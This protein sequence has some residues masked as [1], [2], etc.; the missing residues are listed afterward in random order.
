MRRLALLPTLLACLTACLALPASAP[1]AT[2]PVDVGVGRADITPPTGYTMMG[3]VRSDAKIVGQHTRLWARVIVLRQ[4]GRKVALVAE[5]LNGIPGGMLAQAA[6]A[7]K[8]IGYSQQ[9][10]LDSASHTHAAPTSFYNFSTY[11]S[12]FM[13]VRSPT[14][15]DLQGTVDPQLYAF[16]VRRLALAIRRADQNL[17]PGAVGWGST[18]IEDLTANRSLEAHLANH[19]IHLPYGKGSP[20]M[21]PDGVLH[22]IDPDASVLRVD[23]YIGKRRVP[24]GMWSAFANHGTVNKFQFD[25]YNEDHHGA[26]THRVETEVRRAGKVPK[27]QDV[28]NAYGNTDEGDISSGLARSGPAASDYVGTVESVAFMHAWREAGTRM[29]RSPELDWRWTRMCFCGQDTKVGPV[30]DKGAFGLSE[31]TGSEEGRGPLF[32]VT[33]TP[34]EGDH[35]PVG[36]GA[37]LPLPANPAVDPAQGD[38][39]VVGAPLD[40]PK[41]VPLMALRVGDRVIVS[42]PGEMTAEMGR[43]VRASVLGAMGGSGVA[44]AVIA[45]LANEYADY[46]VTPEEYDEQHYEGG[47]TIYGRASSVALQEAL[48]KLAGDLAAGRPAPDAY[49]FDPVNGLSPNAGPFPTGADRASATRRPAASAERLS[50][51]AFEWQGAPRGYDRPLDSAFVVVQRQVTVKTKAKP[52]RRK[53]RRH[54]RRRRGHRQAPAFTGKVRAAGTVKKWRTVDSDLGL[55][56]LWTVADNGIYHAH[57]EVPLDAPGGSYRF[58]VRANHYT[59]ESRPFAVV[60]SRA[61][62]ALPVNGDPGT[63]AIELRYP[64]PQSH[65]AV[66]DPPGDASA[67]LTHRPARAA[68]G[69]ATF[70]VNGK[71]VTTRARPNGVFEVPAPAGATVELKPGAAADSHGNA[72]AN[73]LTLHP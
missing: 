36:A 8:D 63:V 7:D 32:D 3:W 34:L 1:A 28:V 25:F 47:A 21:D 2:A 46:F 42:I 71:P 59:I 12:V 35:L 64:Q 52:K 27:G 9:N 70:V 11:N 49:P 10:V 26:A 38:K 39:I 66:G 15:F 4:G 33:R 65:E 56:I 68:G 40:V 29:Q 61:L 57:W 48:T 62:T 44:A 23:K 53:H 58:V 6:E 31:F 37:N 17:G 19:G 60:G 54:R 45:G 13:T 14:D 55:N 24:V 18:S 67:T 41:A 43:R 73:A 51:P 5:D 22:T 69:S 72:N 30:A 20:G 50:H 16:M